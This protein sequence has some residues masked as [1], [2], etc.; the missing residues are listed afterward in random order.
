M[1]AWSPRRSWQSSMTCPM[2]SLG[3]TIEA[4]MNGSR[5]SAMRAGSGM[6]L[7]RVDLELLAV[8]E[9]DLEADAR[10][11]RQQLEVVLALQALAHDVH[12]QQPEEAA[13]EAEAERVARLGLPGQ[14]GVVERELLQRVAQVG[15]VVGV[16]REQA[17]EDHRLDLAVAG[18]RLGGAVV[19]GR[20]RVADAQPGDVLDAGDEEA[21]LAGAQL[22]GAAII[23]GREEADVVDLGLGAGGHRADRL[24]L[25]EDAVDDADVGDDAAVLVELGVEDQRARRRVGVAGRRRDL[26]RRAPRGRPRRP[27][28]SCPR[29]AGCVSAGSPSSSETS[30]ATRSGSAPGQV[31]LVQARD[32]LEPGV[33]GQVG[34]GQRLGLDALRRV[35]DEQRAL[36]RR[37]AARDL[38]GE[39][40]V[41]RACR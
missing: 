17:A 6:S 19:L 24:A 21:D 18:Q 35:D 37:Q 27:R 8:G 16:D 39:V 41:A 5:I 4:L 26:L 14:R 25:A 32:Q 20:Q 22:V 23:A 40:D 7:G 12:V 15:V 13:A 1:P 9:R 30:S 28:P 29:C 2:Y 34:V 38:V 31:D 10:H 36:A 11:R 3:V 33:D